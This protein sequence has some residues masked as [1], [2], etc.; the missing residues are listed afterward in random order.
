[1]LCVISV[2]VVCNRCGCYVSCMENVCDI[3]RMLCGS[4]VCVVWNFS[5][6][7]ELCVCCVEQVWMLCACCM[8]IVWIL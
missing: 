5:E 1:M 7:C 2:D 8:E 3:V 4:G 6:I